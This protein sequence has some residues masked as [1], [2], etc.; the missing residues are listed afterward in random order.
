MSAAS[1]CS[2]QP[3]LPCSRDTSDSGGGERR[4]T[5]THTHTQKKGEIKWLSKLEVGEDG[6]AARR[7]L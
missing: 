1:H 3:W 6:A 7:G 5:T 2:N 4:H